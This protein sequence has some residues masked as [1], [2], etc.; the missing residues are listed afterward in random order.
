[1]TKT[2]YGVRVPRGVQKDWG[3]TTMSRSGGSE[4]FRRHSAPAGWGDALKCVVW[5]DRFGRCRA[6]VA[7][8]ANGR[9][10]LVRIDANGVWKTSFGE[11][12]DG[13]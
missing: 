11:V 6:C 3:V 4:W 7:H 12:D 8:Y 2:A 9:S 5:R 1:M 13:E 10:A